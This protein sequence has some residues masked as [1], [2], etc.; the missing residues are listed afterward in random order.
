MQT[1]PTNATAKLPPATSAATD[2]APGI[3]SASITDTLATLGVDPETGLTRTEVDVRQ[4]QHG[5]NEV[6]VQKGHPVVTLLEKF[7][8]LSAWMLER[9]GTPVVYTSGRGLTDGM[10]SM[11]A[12]PSRFVPKPYRD[13]EVIEIVSAILRA[14]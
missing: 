6:A 10:E 1:A 11:F 13:E 8:G 7:W 5:A 9:D 3:A 12:E 4:K 14:P 2:K